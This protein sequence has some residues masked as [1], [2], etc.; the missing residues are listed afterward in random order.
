MGVQKLKVTY[1]YVEKW[2][3][4]KEALYPYNDELN[5]NVYDKYLEL[6]Q[7]EKKVIFKTKKKFKCYKIYTFLINSNVKFINLILF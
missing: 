4:E 5:D 7:K 1:E 2:D 3:E 6:A